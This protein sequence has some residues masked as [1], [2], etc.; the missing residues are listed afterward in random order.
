MVLAGAG[1]IWLRFIEPWQLYRQAARDLDQR[2]R[3]TAD[4]L[5]AAVQQAGG[6]FPQ[7]H[8][9]WSRALLRLGQPQE[10][11]GCFSV[12]PEPSAL[13][14]QDLLTLADEARQSGE[15]LL[16]TLALEAIPAHSE[17]A[18][19]AT[20]RRMELLLETG[21]AQEAQTLGRTLPESTPLT[22]FLLAQASEQLSDPPAAAEH[23]QTALQHADAF[24]PEQIVYARQ[25]LLRLAIAMGHRALAQEC[26][27]E[28]QKRN[29]VSERDRLPE[30]E[31]R[32]MEGDLDT[33]W[34]LVNEVLAA[35]PAD[36]SALQL[37][38][39]LALD[40]GALAE[41]EQDLRRVLKAQPHNK[42][43]H[44]QL[45]QVLQR[46]GRTAEAQPH[47]E[48][49]RRL[50]ELSVRLLDLLRQSP[51]DS[52]HEQTRLTELVHL[53]EQLG[54][55]QRAAEARQQVQQNKQGAVP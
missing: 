37:R 1:W 52:Q 25:H 18:V 13:D 45:A 5:A 31:L 33:A 20:H 48:E 12:I 41:A 43:A 46:T 17:H 16:A 27:A 8:L 6:E 32:R 50:T 36:V 35:T 14:A 55:P 23:Y 19:D 22:Q 44:Y 11:L 53:Y 7:A 42:S 10:A 9:L 54:Q 24:T 3:E 29:A 2:P 47:F 4:L 38:G 15:P 49:N 40:R 39:T 21:R 28:L 30:A 51:G 34:K 26:L